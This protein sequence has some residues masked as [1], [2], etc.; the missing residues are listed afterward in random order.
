MNL[1]STRFE[2]L[3]GRVLS[4]ALGRKPYRCVGLKDNSNINLVLYDLRKNLFCYININENLLY[5]ANT[6][7][8]LIN[9]L[10]KMLL[11][12]IRN[13]DISIVL[14]VECWQV[15]CI[16]IKCKSELSTLSSFTDAAHCVHGDI[17]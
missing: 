13:F 14:T 10:S 17:L 15:N 2:V 6:I 9:N 3:S 1:Q 16:C 11:K 4:C 12:F 7:K 5:F 8:L